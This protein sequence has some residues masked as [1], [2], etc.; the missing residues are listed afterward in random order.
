[1]AG[2]AGGIEGPA[3]LLAMGAGFRSALG[4]G[5]IRKAEGGPALREVASLLFVAHARLPHFFLRAGGRRPGPITPDARP[6]LLFSS[7]LRVLR[8]ARLFRCPRQNPPPKL[9]VV[10][11]EGGRGTHCIGREPFLQSEQ[12][13][14][15]GVTSWCGDSGRGPLGPA[16]CVAGVAPFTAG[17]GG[18]DLLG[19]K[20]HRPIGEHVVAAAKVVIVRFE[21]PRGG[22]LPGR[23][24]RRGADRGARE[25]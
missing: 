6:G 25:R 24:F 18:L 2:D 4:R 12:G 15:P 22:Q 16:T 19:N 5:Y 10:P 11:K 20:A 7:V 13:R 3:A 23:V 1:M 14:S 8:G 9:A 21:S 17:L